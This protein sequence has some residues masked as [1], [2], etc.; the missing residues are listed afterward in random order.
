MEKWNMSFC[1]KLD[2]GKR[3]PPKLIEFEAENDNDAKL[4]I[5]NICKKIV[6]RTHKL[7]WNYFIVLAV[8]YSDIGF[9]GNR[10]I[11]IKIRYSN[12][13]ILRV[14]NPDKILVQG[15]GPEALKKIWE[16]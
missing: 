6:S 12:K 8:P 7:K 5:I 1:F 10:M 3:V 16:D 2:C 11:R 14:K 4:K 13:R 15:Y 9:D